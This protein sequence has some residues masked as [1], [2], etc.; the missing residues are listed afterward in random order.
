MKYYWEEYK[1]LNEYGNNKFYEKW[2]NQLFFKAFN[3]KEHE[4]EGLPN[5]VKDSISGFPY[6]NGGLFT[7]NNNDFDEILIED[8]KF[9]KIYDFFEK[10]NFTIKEDMP[11]ENEVAVDPQ[12]I[13]YVYESLANVADEI[14]DRKDMGI[15]YTPKVEVDFMCRR[16]LVEYLD[17]N[18]ENIPKNEIYKF[19]FDDTTKKSKTEYFDEN[20]KWNELKEV[21]DDLSVVDPACG[22]GAFLVGMLNVLTELYNIIYN[23][24]NLNINSFQTKFKII[25]RSLYGVDVMPWAIRAAELRLWLQLIIETNIPI[26]DLKANPLLPNLDLNLRIG[27]SLVQE[28]GSI[29]FTPRIT[30]LPEKLSYKLKNLKMQKEKYFENSPTAE[31][32][33]TKDFCKQEVLLFKYI[34]N[35]E[36][37]EMKIMLSKIAS[38]K[39]SSLFGNSNT[40]PINEDKIRKK[41][42]NRIKE[43]KNEINNLKNIYEQL[44]NPESK[45]FIWAI[46]FAEI[47]G[48]K[49]GF[50]IV[51]G[52]PPYIE[53]EKIS[54]PNKLKKEITSEDKKEYK[55]KCAE[56]ISKFYP[57]VKKVNLQSDYSIYFF[58]HGL[59]LL[60]KTGTFCF[61]TSN[62]WLD[63]SYGSILQE[64]LLKN[65][66][67][68]AIYDN[69]SKR[70]FKH[71]DINTTISLFGKTKEI[72][73][74]IDVNYKSQLNSIA[75]FI[76][77]KKP[78]EESINVK[79]LIDIE[80]IDCEKANE[81]KKLIKNRIENNEYNIFP[82]F[83][84]N[85]LNDGWIYPDGKKEKNFNSGQYNGNKWNSKFLRAPKIFYKI[86]EKGKFITVDEIGT[87][88]TYLNTGG[89]DNFYFIDELENY[90]KYSSIENKEFKKTFKVESEFIKPLVKSSKELTKIM[91]NKNIINSRILVI[92]ET[93]NVSNLKVKKYIKFGEEKK[94]NER[95]GTSN[96][97]PWWK[98]PP[99]AKNGGELLFPRNYNDRL[100]VF[101]NPEK[102]ISNRFFRFKTTESKKLAFLL[103]STI[104]YLMMEI[105]GKTS[106]GG[107]ALE[108]GKPE[109]RLLPLLNIEDFNLNDNSLLNRNICSVFDECGIDKLKPIRDQTPKAMDDRAKLDNIIFDALNLNED[110]R[111]EVYWSLCELVKQRL[112]KSQ[113]VSRNKME[114]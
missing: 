47:F 84:K 4:I 10:Y 94:Y 60:N 52:N 41:D 110:E 49:D 48:D 69:N 114:C 100:M 38:T 8:E 74:K 96:R 97:S 85:L 62:S 77:F 88:E 87:I 105:Y 109:I 72:T 51:I 54:P 1:K 53:Q 65:I 15:F 61:I 89:A 3:N 103:N 23:K 35:H 90:N 14:Y 108:L 29:K 64:F 7:K 92:N 36:I 55:K 71:A 81:L 9:K 83:Q 44:N 86:L 21:L 25:Q 73:T 78:F 32:K 33:T 16:T 111:N 70:S 68:I 50:D 95:S 34:I 28:M 66:H 75:K 13:G 46:D 107:G 18:L 104:N 6:L 43:L 11:F 113:S 101:Y 102:I 31:F 106:L 22:S 63:A 27:D 24:L 30:R 37:K 19:I 42:E 26:E 59:N 80:N 112:D 93:K 76:M 58:F 12:M 57:E 79:N 91:I 98:L 20:N 67:I 45:P 56:L 5:E 39:Q 99:Q 40:M 17:K 82:I 2:L